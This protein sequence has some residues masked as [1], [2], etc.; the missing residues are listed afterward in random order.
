MS[1][2]HTGVSKHLKLEEFDQAQQQASMQVM[3]IA[4][5]QFIYVYA[6]VC[7]YQSVCFLV[8][9]TT[10][11]YFQYMYTMRPWLC[12]WSQCKFAQD[13]S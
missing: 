4:G 2:F 9:G 11:M 7:M 10:C 5:T 8:H 13:A 6:C 3:R 1:L 12:I